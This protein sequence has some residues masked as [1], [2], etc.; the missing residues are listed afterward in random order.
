MAKRVYRGC[1]VLVCGW[2]TSVDLIE[3]HMLDFDM[4]LGNGLVSLVLYLT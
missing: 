3:L 2:E 4:F 1:I